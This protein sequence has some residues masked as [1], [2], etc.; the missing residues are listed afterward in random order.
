MR[1]QGVATDRG[2]GTGRGF[3]D[4]PAHTQRAPRRRDRRDC[5]WLYVVTNCAGDPQL[6]EPVKD[7]AQRPWHEVTKV[8]HYYLSVDALESP[9]VLREDSQAYEP[10]GS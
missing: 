1:S 4:H 2:E 9:M 5:Y 6:E 10:E 3:R 8:A 7:P